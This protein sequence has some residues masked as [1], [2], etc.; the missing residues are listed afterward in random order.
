[1]P[2]CGTHLDLLPKEV[3]PKSY[4]DRIKMNPQC[5]SFMHLHLGFD[6][7]GISEDLKIHHIVV[8][9]WERGVDA[10]QNVVLI[11][12]PSVLSS[13]LAP[14]GK[15]VLHAYMPGTKPFGLWEELDRKSAEYKEHNA[16]RSEVL[17]RAVERA[18]GPGFDHEKCEVGWNPL[19]HQRFLRRNR[20]TYGPAIQA[21]KG[22][23]PGHS[24]PIP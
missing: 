9:D 11:S 2:L 1:M 19:T 12:I 10:D 6:T 22:T 18:V 4:Q 15:H 16:K 5:E 14:P 8:N 20:G 3:I 23:F 13:D 17:W 21:G 7:E 24:T